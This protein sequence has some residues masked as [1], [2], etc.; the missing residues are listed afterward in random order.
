MQTDIRKPWN[1]VIS[2]VT[3]FL[4]CGTFDKPTS[5]YSDIQLNQSSWKQAQSFISNSV[6]ISAGS[7]PVV[8]NQ[9]NVIWQQ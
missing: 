1:F 8:L 6:S 4:V 7:K 5:W 9:S 2:S 3:S